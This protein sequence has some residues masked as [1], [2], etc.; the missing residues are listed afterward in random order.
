[1]QQPIDI[2]TVLDNAQKL[3]KELH[4]FINYN[5]DIMI[6]RKISYDS[7]RD[8]FFMMKIGRLQIEVENLKE[9]LRSPR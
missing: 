7:M 8:I 2:D 1:M 3:Q 9:K 6:K 5:S 4:E